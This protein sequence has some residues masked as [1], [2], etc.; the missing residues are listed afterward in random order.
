MNSVGE[1]ERNGNRGKEEG[2]ERRRGHCSGAS[3]EKKAVIT[4]VRVKRGGEGEKEEIIDRGK[5]PR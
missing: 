2:E 5:R 4:R 1:K 3:K